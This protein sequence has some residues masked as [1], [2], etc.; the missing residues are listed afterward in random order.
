[1]FTIYAVDGRANGCKGA[2]QYNLSD[3][4]DI[5]KLKTWKKILKLLVGAIVQLN[6]NLDVED[7]LCNC[8]EGTVKYVRIC[9]STNSAKD[10]GTIYTQF[11]N[12]KSGNKRKV[13]FSS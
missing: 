13:K 2:F 6:D 5:S 9:T 3:D 7:K 11:D 1:M 12:E 4:I 8:S 10:G